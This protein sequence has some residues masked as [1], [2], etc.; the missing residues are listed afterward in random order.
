[1]KIVVRLLLAAALISGFFAC[2]PP[3]ATFNGVDMSA[4]DASRA[5]LEAARA[6]ASAGDHEKAA[7]LFED[8]ARRFP[9]SEEADEAL[10]GAGRSWE[11]VGKPLK[12]RGAYELLLERYPRSDKAQEAGER[13]AALGGSVA[14]L[15]AAQEAFD[16]LPEGKKLAEAERLAV[17]AEGAGDAAQALHWRKEALA[18]ARTP[19]QTSRAEAG[20]RQLVEGMAAADVERLAPLEDDPIAA[21][22]LQYQ[23][24]M[25]HQQ[26]RDWDELERALEDFISQNPGH[27][28]VGKARDLL[29][30][31]A[32]RGV[33]EPRKV[34]VVLPLSG[35]Y[36]AFGQQLLDGIELAARGSAIELIVRDDKGEPTDAAAAVER[37]LYEDHV[38]AV[39]GG[40]LVT[41]A[42]AAAAKADELGL[43]FVT[44]SRSETLVEGSEWVFRDMLTNR[45]MAEAIAS[46]AVERR[47]MQRLAILHPEI[48]YGEEL[49]DLFEAQVEARGGTISQIQGYEDKSTTFSE[50]IRKLVGKENLQDR[51][52]YQ[53]KLAE[54]RAQKLDSRRHRNAVEKMRNSISPRIDFEAIFIPDQWRTIALVAPALAFEDVITSW[55]DAVDVD[56]TRRTTGQDVKPVMLLGANL[57]N[58]P[59]L[60]TR[61]GKYVNCSVFVDGFFAGS[62]RPEVAMFADAFHAAKG[63]SPGLLEAYGFEAAHVVRQTI[64]RERPASR[65]ELVEGLMKVESLPGPMGPTSI[66]EARELRHPLFF[67]FIDAGTIREAELDSPDGAL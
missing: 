35:P 28:Y 47:G 3:R 13:V 4:D 25:V 62:S 52:E 37:L 67:L 66:N 63:R 61:A 15:A 2:V 45:E 36:K 11:A 55:C 6:K 22:L 46:F 24:A 21:P 23:L 8:L 42:Q 34:G 50:P 5:Q 16:R 40:V 38:I 18:Q 9:R 26:H 53:R 58:H 14:P 56:R 59:E 49:R 57:W 51:P 19:A 30:A 65:R 7:E 48:P 27:A 20:L 64:E 33:V 17:A 60:P 32:D 41:E 31:V 39:I 43:P 54:I 12:A 29:R 10:L 1:M 44:F